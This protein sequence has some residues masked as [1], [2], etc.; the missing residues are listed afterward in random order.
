M[1]GWGGAWG[2]GAPGYRPP[3]WSPG[4]SSG[5]DFLS[6]APHDHGLPHPPARRSHRQYTAVTYHLQGGTTSLVTSAAATKHEVWCDRLGDP[7]SGHQ[8]GPPTAPPGPREPPAQHQLE[9]PLP[10][11][12]SP[13]PVNQLRQP[14]LTPP[15]LPNFRSQNPRSRR[16]SEGNI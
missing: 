7:S 15:P 4:G 14:T 6:G 2:C 8:P 16:Q 11:D 3:P 12:T 1:G 13:R 5:P 9:S 10:E